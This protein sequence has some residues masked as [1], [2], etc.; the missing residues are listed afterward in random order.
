MDRCELLTYLNSPGPEKVP[1]RPCC[2]ATL[3]VFV[4][5]PPSAIGEPLPSCPALP[6]LEPV[7]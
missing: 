3:L 5:E 6:A 7:S 4:R 2:V 1:V